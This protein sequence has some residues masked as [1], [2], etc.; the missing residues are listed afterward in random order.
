M[1][2]LGNIFTC[3]FSKCLKYFIYNVVV[4]KIPTKKLVLKKLKGTFLDTKVAM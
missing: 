4:G 2:K 3:V 1:K